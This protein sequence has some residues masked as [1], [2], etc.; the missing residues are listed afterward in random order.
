[1]ARDYSAS[2]LLDT[3]LAGPAYSLSP[4]RRPNA[5]QK[6]AKCGGVVGARAITDFVRV[7]HVECDTFNA[8]K[9]LNSASPQIAIPIELQVAQLSGDSVPIQSKSKMKAAKFERQQKAAQKQQQR[10]V[11]KRGLTTTAK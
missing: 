11:K 10:Q 3:Y 6:C 8:N 1:M 9:L 2:E 5:G 7:W 4:S